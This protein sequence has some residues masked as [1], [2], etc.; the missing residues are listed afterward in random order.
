MP[1]RTAASEPVFNKIQ[2]FGIYNQK[3]GPAHFPDATFSVLYQLI[4]IFMSIFSLGGEWYVIC[5]VIY[6][7]HE[8][9]PEKTIKP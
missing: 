8:T 3:I 2:Y 1:S 4:C 9:W 7:E 6:R 5:T